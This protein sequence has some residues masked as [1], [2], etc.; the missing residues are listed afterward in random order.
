MFQ[1]LTDDTDLRQ[2]VKKFLLIDNV[3]RTGCC[4]VTVRLNSNHPCYHPGLTSRRSFSLPAWR[5]S[6]SWKIVS[7]EILSWLKV[8][9]IF[10]SLWLPLVIFDFVNIPMNG[11]DLHSFWSLSSWC[12]WCSE[13]ALSWKHKWSHISS[14]ALWCFTNIYTPTFHSAAGMKWLPVQHSIQWSGL[15]I[16][17]ILMHFRHFIV[18]NVLFAVNFLLAVLFAVTLLFFQWHSLLISYSRR[19]GRRYFFFFAFSFCDTRH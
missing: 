19:S 18:A 11:K 1:L 5:W 16:W 10:I 9:W 4:Q 8:L 15:C 2:R 17:E 6:I 12:L 13:R 7:S 3:S 14:S